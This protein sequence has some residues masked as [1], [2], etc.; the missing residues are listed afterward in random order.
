MSSRVTLAQVVENITRLSADVTPDEFIYDFL[1]C[2]GAPKATIARLKSG[3]LNV[4]KK[5]G[6]TLLKTKVYFEPLRPDLLKAAQ[7]LQAIEVAK[8]DSRISANKPR[9]LLATDFKTLAAF[10]TKRNDTVEFPI[11]DLHEHYT[12]FLPLAGMEKSTVH[13]EAEADV[14]AAENMAKLYDVIRA[15]NPRLRGAAQALQRFCRV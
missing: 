9:F 11:V 12:F 5:E 7:P 10:D 15:D 14:K 13:A 3:A 1:T 2:F 6:C 8:R 4:A